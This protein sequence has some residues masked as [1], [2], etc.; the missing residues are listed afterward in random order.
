MMVLLEEHSVYSVTTIM[1]RS[2]LIL[3]ITLTAPA[4]TA[5]LQ[6]YPEFG[7]GLDY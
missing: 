6:Q 5:I 4:N 1:I 2:R 3:A 7:R